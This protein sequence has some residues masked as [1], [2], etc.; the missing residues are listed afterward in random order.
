MKKIIVLLFMVMAPLVCLASNGETQHKTQ[1]PVVVRTYFLTNISPQRA[2]EALKPYIFNSSFDTP[3]KMITVTILERN[4]ET[5]EKLLHK[6][7]EK[8]KTIK[9]RIYTF[10]GAYE[11]EPPAP[12]KNRE[13]DG[14]IDELRKVLNFQSYILDGTSFITVREG[15]RFN[16]LTLSSRQL[17]PAMREIELDNIS[18]VPGKGTKRNIDLSLDTR[19]R[20]QTSLSIPENGYVVAGVSGMRDKEESLILILNATIED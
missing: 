10:I 8:R 20:L 19:F 2:A 3:R 6:L 11:G 17:H 18:I 4:L 14:V 7:D 16:H 13:L 15:S 1:E 12:L 9:L 5:F